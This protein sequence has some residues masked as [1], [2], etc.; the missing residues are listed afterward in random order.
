MPICHICE[1]EL[2]NDKVKDQ[3]HITS[4]YRG[5]YI[6]IILHSLRGYD[7]HFIVRNFGKYKEKIDIIPNNTE[8]FMS[9]S[10]GNDR[11]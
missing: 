3:C 2:G 7:S 1:K 10:I 8:K 6:P 11:N 5:G 4:I 9:I